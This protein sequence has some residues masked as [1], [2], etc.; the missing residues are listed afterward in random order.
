MYL[1]PNFLS[2]FSPASSLFYFHSF[3]TSSFLSHSH[4]LIHL[5]VSLISPI[6]SYKFLFF[7]LWFHIINYS[8]LFADTNYNLSISII[9]ITLALS[10]K[11]FKQKF[12]RSTLC[13]NYH[14]HF[15]HL[16]FITTHLLRKLTL[17]WYT[18]TY[19][20]ARTYT[21]NICY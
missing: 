4:I 12:I 1:F 18:Y 8:N 17:Y 15:I 5:L 21:K 9:F 13:G 6:L 3:S 19:I 16:R 7:Y 14:A 20:R 10:L 11:Q 2:A